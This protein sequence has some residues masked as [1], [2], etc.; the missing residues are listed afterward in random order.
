MKFKHV[1][2]GGTFDRLHAGHKKLL[3]AC[4]KQGGKVT[5]GIT[6]RAM[7]RHKQYAQTIQPYSIRYNNVEKITKKNNSRVSI[8]KIRDLYGS[9]L[10]DS[11]IDALFVTEDT[12][13]G[14]KIINEKRLQLG[15]KPLSIITIPL[16]YDEDGEKISSERIRGGQISR[17]GI[18]YYKYLISKAI[19]TLP[20]SLRE[21]LRS[22]LGRVI[23]SMSNP[24]HPFIQKM[25]DVQD[26]QSHV[27]NI[28]V[29]DIIT[30]N[31]RKGGVI[32]SISIIDGITQ[33]KALNREEL[34]IIKQIDCTYA[35]NR[36][37]TIQREAVKALKELLLI[38]HPGARKQLF[39]QGEEDLLTLVV[40][41]LAPLDSY[42]WY[43]Q[44]GVGSICIHVTEKMKE[45]VYNLIRKFT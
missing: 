17:E 23:S 3:E 7:T 1:V 28:S 16:E 31:L 6:D 18:N 13:Q 45:K 11:S 27:L 34:Q 25:K 26:T 29:G 32:P 36:K 33:R 21:E 38:G 37:G 30:Y 22:P 42:V 19:H 43:G 44:Q 24:F 5:I 4:M 8:L 40:A 35:P 12:L 2:C 20:E 14:A 10:N 41:L 39:I 9:T 15:M